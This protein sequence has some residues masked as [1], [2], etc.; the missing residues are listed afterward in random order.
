[1]KS[2][3]CGKRTNSSRYCDFI[4]HLQT[5]GLSLWG[6]WVE[7]LVN[8]WICR[9]F[10]FLFSI[11]LFTYTHPGKSFSSFHWLSKGPYAPK[12]TTA[13]PWVKISQLFEVLSAQRQK[14]PITIH[15]SWKAAVVILVKSGTIHA[16]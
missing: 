15:V 3:G 1:V 4:S 11:W 6:S 7:K 10:L 12:L 5:I 16:F 14:I 8:S 2:R 9:G 13:I